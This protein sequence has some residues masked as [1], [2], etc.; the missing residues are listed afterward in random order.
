MGC[1]NENQQKYIWIGV[2]IVVIGL[3]FCADG[4]ARDL[5]SAAVTYTNT[6]KNIGQAMSVAGVVAGGICMQLPG[7]ANFGRNVLAGGLVGGVCSF[8]APAFVGLLT[9]V[10]GGN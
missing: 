4:F 2:A 9:S 10:F 1:S 7:V 8:G 5:G 6:L 3:G